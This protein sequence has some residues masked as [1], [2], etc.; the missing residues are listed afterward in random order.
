[1]KPENNKTKDRRQF[2]NSM[3]PI[4]A[5]P[6]MGFGNLFAVNSQEIEK[7]KFQKDWTQSYADFFQWR[8]DYY[9]SIMK[10]FSKYMGKENLLKMIKQ[11]V[12]DAG[13]RTEPDNP[14]HTFQ[15]FTAGGKIYQNM[16]TETVVRKTATVY[17][18]HVTECLWKEAFAKRNATDI[19]FAT[20]CY[21]DFIDA[22]NYHS[23]IKL[24]R[25]KTLMQG[26][27]CCNHCWKWED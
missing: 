9:I 23:K 2:I 6:C 4:C 10:Q 8:Y 1:M 26:H 18:I 24:Y 22:Q 12:D 19:G 11:A 15:K 14:E 16:M 17:E 3:I 13:K 27:D 25:T 7:H 20:V 5:F 21:G